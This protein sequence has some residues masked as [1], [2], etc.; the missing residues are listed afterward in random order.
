MHQNVTMLQ[1]C[2]EK[3]RLDPSK[4]QELVGQFEVSGSPA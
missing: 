4:L 1:R 3:V 2:A